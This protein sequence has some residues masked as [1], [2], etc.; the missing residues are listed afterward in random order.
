MVEEEQQQQPVRLLV[1][2]STL[3]LMS[4]ARDAE[5]EI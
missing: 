5:K 4:R 2:P 3:T 1:R